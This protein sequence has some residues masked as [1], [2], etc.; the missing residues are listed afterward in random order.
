MQ[1]NSFHDHCT[2]KPHSL[3]VFPNFNKFKLLDWCMY[4]YNHFQVQRFYFLKK[5]KYHNHYVVVDN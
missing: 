3:I 1:F 2:I 5:Y 4:L